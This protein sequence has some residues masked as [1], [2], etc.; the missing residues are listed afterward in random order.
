M[1]QEWFAMKKATKIKKEHSK[2]K[3][4]CRNSF[5]SVRKLNNKARELIQNVGQ[6]DKRYKVA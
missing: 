2:M 6:K 4:N 3:T 1:K 5:N